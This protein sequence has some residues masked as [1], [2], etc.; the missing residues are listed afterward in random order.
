MPRFKFQT[1]TGSII[2]EFD[3]TSTV[4]QVRMFLSQTIERK[5]QGLVAVAE[6]GSSFHAVSRLADSQ[7]M[8]DV[9]RKAVILLDCEKLKPEVNVPKHDASDDQSPKSSENLLSFH[10]FLNLGNTKPFR[11]RIFPVNSLHPPPHTP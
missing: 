3:D 1:P 11:N 9:D 6:K 7:R 2:M 4:Y 5:V 10:D 8:R